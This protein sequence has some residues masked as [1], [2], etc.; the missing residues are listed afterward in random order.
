VFIF[1]STSSDGVNWTPAVAI[2]S[3]SGVK[4]QVLVDNARQRVHLIYSAGGSVHH[5]IVSN[6][7][8]SAPIV[9]ANSSEGEAALD[10]ATGYVHLVSTLYYTTGPNTPEP[11]T[12]IRHQDTIYAYWNGVSWSGPIKVVNSDDTA[13][14]GVAAAPGAGVMLTWF[15]DWFQHFNT[16]GGAD[17]P[18]V[19]RSAFGAGLGEF[20][21]RQPVSAYYPIPQNDTT[22]R[23]IYSPGDGKFVLV[24][25]HDLW[26]GHS[27][28]YRYTWK[29]NA[30]SPAV[31]VSSAAAP[32]G[33]TQSLYVGA[34]TSQSRVVYVFKA[35]AIW[36]R[37]E[38]NGILSTS[39]NIDT[40][41]SDR[42]YTRIGIY[43]NSIVGTGFTVDQAG[44]LHMIVYGTKGGVTGLYYLHQ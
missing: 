19:A 18:I 8:I 28:I 25:D 12:R 7:V 33:W 24:A 44:T 4:L 38:S 15:Q 9:A 20:S 43:E 3:G 17:S 10:P 29:D 35:D 26:P 16:M 39:Q 6:G 31:D 30:W 37:T 5:R 41:L 42:G 2:N 40:Y 23:L 14:P 34:A 32:S 27:A 1:Y 36:M 13:N 21:L 22:L 11:I